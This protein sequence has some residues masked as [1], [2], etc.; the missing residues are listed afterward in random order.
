MKQ[1]Y[2]PREVADAI[3]QARDMAEL[4]DELD[5][6]EKLKV[7]ITRLESRLAD[8]ERIQANQR[9]KLDHKVSTHMFSV[10]YDA[11]TIFVV[12]TARLS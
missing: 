4:Q 3:E 10:N 12:I 6:A 11:L 9:K 2:P 8:Q 1:D 5:N 7:K